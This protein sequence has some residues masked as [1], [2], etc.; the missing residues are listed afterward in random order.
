MSDI[1]FPNNDDPM[2]L[3]YSGNPAQEEAVGPRGISL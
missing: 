2:F 3:A 1:N